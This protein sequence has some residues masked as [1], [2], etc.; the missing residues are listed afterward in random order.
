MKLWILYD[1][2]K[3]GSLNQCIGLASA[4]NL[5]YKVY[6]VDKNLFYRFFPIYFFLNPLIVFLRSVIILIQ[7]SW[8]DLIISAG[9]KSGSVSVY[10]RQLS[11]GKT[12]VIQILNPKIKISLFDLIVVPE[13]DFLRG[14]NIL[15]ILGSITNISTQKLNDSIQ[16]FN[17]L[18]NHLPRPLIS[19]FIGGNSKYYRFNK[20]EAYTLVQDLKRI[21]KSTNGSIILT[22]SRRTCINS[23]NV[24]KKG[25]QNLPIIIYDS[26]EQNPYFAYIALGDFLIITEDSISM[27]CEVCFIRKPIYIY[28]FR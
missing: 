12:R 14:K 26:G 3:T 2:K 10:I 18:V 8:P 1:S 22:T 24:L 11:N 27:I 28:S 17:L 19:V 4:F 6:S 15:P 21:V 5:S 23:K 16:K 13:H 9:R 25:L 20:F 7:F